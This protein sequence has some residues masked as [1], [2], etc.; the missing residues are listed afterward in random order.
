MRK[1]HEPKAMKWMTGERDIK[2]KKDNR[3]KGARLC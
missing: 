1:G 3:R 2:Q